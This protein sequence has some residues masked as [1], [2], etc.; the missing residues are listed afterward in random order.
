[1]ALGV[2][3]D[4]RMGSAAAPCA[5]LARPHSRPGAGLATGR[6]RANLSR[7]AKPGSSSGV[8]AEDALLDA[9]L[10]AVTGRQTAAVEEV[11]DGLGSGLSTL[12]R[13]MQPRPSAFPPGTSTCFVSA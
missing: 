8:R 5:A 7:A 11:T 10:A 12:Q 9:L 1:M 6:R 4:A 2:V 13:M 3:V